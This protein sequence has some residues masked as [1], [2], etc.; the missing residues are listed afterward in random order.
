MSA[1]SPGNVTVMLQRIEAGE[2]EA[3]GE[4][5]PIV[6]QEL[7]RIADYQMRGER[8]DHTLQ[9]TAL[10]NE[11]I[12]Q[13]MQK[14]NIHW[15]D[16]THF[17]MTAALVMRRILANHARSRQSAKRGGDRKKLPLDEAVAAYEERAIDLVTLDEALD[18]LKLEY[19][20]RAALVNLRFF[21]SLG[22][23]EIAKLLGVSERTA[24]TDWHDA[25]IWLWQELR[26]ELH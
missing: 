21:A 10:V 24:K 26:T 18:R 7:R 4:L 25:R 13:L 12:V 20:R 8:K 19:P 1:E 6:L 3:L 5:M 17:Y 15:A 2:P 9:P 23:K 22:F 14:E 16:R 11:A